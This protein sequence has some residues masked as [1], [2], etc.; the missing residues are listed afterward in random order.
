MRRPL[1]TLLVVLLAIPTLSRAQY[2]GDEGFPKL[3][4]RG[5]VHQPSGSR[6]RDQSSLWPELGIDYVLS[7]DENEHP[8]D[9]VSVA[10]TASSKNLMDA[11]LTGLEYMRYWS[12]A[13]EG[14]RGFYYGAGTGVFLEKVKVDEA[15]PSPGVD[16]SGV[17]PGL[18]LVGGY[19]FGDY[20][21]A[22]V[23]Y[24]KLE[25]LAPDVDISGLS[26]FIGAR[27]LL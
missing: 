9:V 23:R 24:I 15:F 5:G 18:T 8:T 17:K 19:S 12:G 27:R 2:G 7:F 3:Q 26:F 4:I 6:A 20:W 25:E 11:T 22:E 10:Y 13:S 1:W 14:T 21:F 16:E